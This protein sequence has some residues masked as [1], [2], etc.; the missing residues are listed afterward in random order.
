MVEPANGTDLYGR[1]FPAVGAP[2]WPA[3]PRLV[4]R[5]TF[6]EIWELPDA[7]PLFS[8]VTGPPARLPATAVTSPGCVVRAQGADQVTVD[9]PHPAVV[10]RRVQYVPGWTATVDGRPVAVR[11]VAGGPFQSVA[12]PSGRSTVRFTY[13]PPGALASVGVA[14]GALLVLIASLVVPVVRAGRRRRASGGAGD[15][16]AESP[17]EPGLDGSPWATPRSRGSS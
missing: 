14:A 11:P 8:A 16:P 10:L 1:P 15:G 5:D 6:A 12:L 17:E 2:P 13:L 4:Y 3:G 9:C 7:A